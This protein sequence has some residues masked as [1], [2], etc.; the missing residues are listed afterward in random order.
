MKKLYY[1]RKSAMRLITAAFIFGVIVGGAVLAGA[2]YLLVDEI[3]AKNLSTEIDTISTEIEW[4]DEKLKTEDFDT[5]EAKK[6]LIKRSN[7]LIDLREFLEKRQRMV[8][9]VPTPPA[10]EKH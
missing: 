4:I 8:L 9:G 6:D 3:I 2:C 10:P 5:E 1:Q 7:D